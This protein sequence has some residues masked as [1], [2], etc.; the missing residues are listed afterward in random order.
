MDEA[1][2]QQ[3]VYMHF[4]RV[5]RK[6]QRPPLISTS[7]TLTGV[8]YQENDGTIPLLALLFVGGLC[9]ILVLTV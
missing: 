8:L 6:D 5:N 4:Y 1:P 9:G 2:Q 7:S 3:E